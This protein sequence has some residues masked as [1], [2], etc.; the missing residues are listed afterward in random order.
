[1]L[2]FCQFEAWGT[3]C[4]DETMKNILVTG[5]A[6]GIGISVVKQLQ[7][8]GY[9]IY[10]LYN[11]SED[12]AKEIQTELENV[13]MLHCDLAEPDNVEQAVQSLKSVPFCAIVNVAGVA[14]GDNVPNFNDRDW[15]TTFQINLVAPL[16]L[17]LGLHENIEAGGSV[18]NVGSTYGVLWGM[19]M[20]LSYGASKAAL[21]N[22]TKSLAV[23]LREQKIRVNA[24]APSIVDTDMTS[25]D[26]PDMLG[27]VSRRT[28]AGRIARP[29]EIAN[30][31]SFLISDK[32]SYINAHTL[33]VDGGYSAWDGTY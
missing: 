7:A 9:K 17:V 2:S 32:A 22:L 24:V 3:V 31:V 16:K 26:T 21:S 18:V 12:N 27:E 10:G 6:R 4:Y 5:A 33:V 20:S 15:A 8:E 19:D 28:P 29:E 30:A 1:M 13:E 11:S 23:Q 25:Q 14:M